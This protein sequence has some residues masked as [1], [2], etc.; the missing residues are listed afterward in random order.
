MKF[1]KV[2]LPLVLTFVLLSGFS[3]KKG[4][5]DVYAFGVSASFTDTVVY[6][7]EIQVLDS[8]ILTKNDFLPKREAYTYQLKN[9]LEYQRNEKNRTCMIYFSE[10]PKK[11]AKERS[12]ILAKYKKD[13]SV[14]LELIL[15]EEF[16]FTKPEEY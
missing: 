9:H 2:A 4:K 16:T 3:L 10:N 8:V 14:R 11:L 13:K 5:K 12:K 15:P 1:I 6:Y 7:T